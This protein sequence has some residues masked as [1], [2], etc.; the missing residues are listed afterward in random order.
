MNLTVRIYKYFIYSI[1][2]S[3]ITYSFVGNEL[4]MRLFV[5]WSVKNVIII[6][7]ENRK[8]PDGIKRTNKSG[9]KKENKK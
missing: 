9:G 4:N 8:N 3:G 6:Q 5:K 2:F 7:K 1:Y